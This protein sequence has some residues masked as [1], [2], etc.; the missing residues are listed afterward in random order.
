M[1]NDISQQ[2]IHSN[3]NGCALHGAVKALNAIGG[4]VPI[5]H[6]SAGCSIF[7]GL[8]ENLPDGSNGLYYRGYMETPATAITEKQVIFGGAARLREQIKNTVKVMAGDLYVVVTGCA[9]EL[10]GDDTPAM[11]REAQE[12]GFPVIA[13]SAPG[14]K[15]SV[16]RGY[17]WTLKALIEHVSSQSS[18]PPGDD[19]LVN[20][21]GIVPKQ[22]V[23]WEGNLQEIGRLLAMAGWQGNRL[24]GFGASLDDWRRIP[25]AAL[26]L[27]LSPWGLPAARILEERFGTPYLYWGYIPVG[28]KDTS[29]LL[30]ELAARL[31]VD[32]DRLESIFQTE[33]KR[34]DYQLQKL[35]QLYIRMD[36]Q[37]EIA[38]VGETSG[39]VGIS[40]FLQEDFGQTVKQ[41]IITDHPDEALR[42]EILKALNG[43]RPV[44]A[45]FSSDGKTTSE[46]LLEVQ[47]EA[48]LGSD[49]EQEV[50]D[51]RSI[52]LLKIS[53]PVRD[54]VF[55][56]HT[57][58]GYSGAINLLQDF[59]EMILK[60][61]VDW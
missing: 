36:F 57:Y 14:F 39:V 40:R 15:G 30:R 47:P 26:N 11:V 33:R 41:V 34:L 2:V 28:E 56:E 21:L 55:L 52:P 31:P 49:L 50:A 54:R 12:Q 27:V 60:H 17:E 20:I 22:D 23:L 16:Y 53:S 51:E 6:S 5:V 45:L 3:R 7:S 24:F 4:I 37:K 1:K 43:Y 58:C 13:V 38:L 10:V 42:P 8:Q 32:G 25:A 59:S 9:P 29:A 44:E 19:R 18:P 48:I 35:A 46:R 61:E